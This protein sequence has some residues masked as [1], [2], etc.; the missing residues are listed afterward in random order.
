VKLAQKILGDCAEAKNIGERS[1]PK[2]A[3]QKGKQKIAE[4]GGKEKKGK[5]ARDQSYVGDATLTTS[6]CDFNAPVQ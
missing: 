4:E 5:S 2:Q 1:N 3:Q 6:R